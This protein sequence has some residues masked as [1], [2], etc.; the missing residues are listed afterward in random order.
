MHQGQEVAAVI[1][2]DRYA[3]AMGW[4]AVEVEYKP[5]QAVVD[6]FKALEKDAPFSGPTK[7]KKQ[8]Y[9]A[10]GK[11]ETKKKQRGRSKR[12]MW[13]CVKRCTSP[14]FMSHR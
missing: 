11:P 7:I 1:A 12:P 5:M 2:V 14:V 9:L 10:L 8:S 4:E 6:P 13:W 3:V